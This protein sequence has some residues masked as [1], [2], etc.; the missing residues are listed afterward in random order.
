M[1]NKAYLRSTFLD[2]KNSIGRFIAITV[3]ILLGVLL[4]VGIKAI[5]PDLQLTADNYLTLT[6]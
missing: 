2:I 1:K 6:I 5:G 3:I 4:F